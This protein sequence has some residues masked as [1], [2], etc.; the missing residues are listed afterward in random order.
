LL[1]ITPS[2][3]TLSS[4]VPPGTFSILAYL[5]ISKLSFPIS[6]PDKIFLTESIAKFSTR[7]P[8]LEANLVPIQLLS[9][10]RISLSSFL[11]IS[12]AISFKIFIPS[13]K[14]V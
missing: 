11:S 5:F 12:T 6:Q 7:L 13:Y 3:T 8:H 14:A 2:N 1:T 10:F 9:A 4:N